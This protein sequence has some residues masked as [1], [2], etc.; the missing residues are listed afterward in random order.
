MEERKK[1]VLELNANTTD[2]LNR[3]RYRLSKMHDKDYTIQE[4]ARIAVKRYIRHFED[5][6][7]EWRDGKDATK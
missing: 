7:T 2:A 5:D 1:I 6:Y 4:A 3:F